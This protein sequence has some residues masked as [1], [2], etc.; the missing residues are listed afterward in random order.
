[1]RLD[2]LEKEHQKQKRQ[3][4]KKIKELEASHKQTTSKD[5]VSQSKPSTEEIYCSMCDFTTTSKQALTLSMARG[6]NFRHPFQISSRTFKPVKVQ[7]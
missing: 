3:S 7:F 2:E 4:E 5:K 6:G 1:M